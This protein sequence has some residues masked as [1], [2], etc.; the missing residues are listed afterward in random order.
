MGT[1]NR[2]DTIFVTLVTKMG[3][4]LPITLNGVSSMN[5]IVTAIRRQ[6]SETRGIVTLRMRNYTQGWSHSSNMLWR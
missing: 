6:S 1:I 4:P 3:S 2:S 5:E